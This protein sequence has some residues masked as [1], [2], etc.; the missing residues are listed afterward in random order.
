MIQLAYI[1]YSPNAPGL[2]TDM[3][4]QKAS[5]T[6]GYL[7][8]FMLYALR[9]RR[10]LCALSSRDFRVAVTPSEMK[11]PPVSYLVWDRTPLRMVHASKG[12]FVLSR[13]ARSSAL[14]VSTSGVSIVSIYWVS[15]SGCARI[16]HY[17]VH[18]VLFT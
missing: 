15:I 5:Y 9:V 3:Y 8:L 18:G 1:L 14:A 16:S 17:L 7:V 11:Y 6:F 10:P 13:T 12:S 2:N 4:L